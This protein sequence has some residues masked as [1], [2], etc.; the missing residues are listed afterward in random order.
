MNT[1]ITTLKKELASYFFSPVGYVIAVL[2]YLFRGWEVY[3]QTRQLA[4][5]GA[6]RDLYS[7]F[8]IFCQSTN[9]M[10]VLVPPI[11]TM[12]CFAEERRSGSLEVLMTAPVRDV[13][14]VLGKW[15]AALSFF[16]LLWLPTLLV[17]WVLTWQ[18]FMGV[19][20]A[21]GPVLSG[22]LG[23]FLLG[24]LFLA[25]GCLTSSLTDNLLLAA[26]SA[27]LFNYTLLAW[28]S[29][30]G[31]L[32]PAEA[33]GIGWVQTIYQHVN[34]FDHLSNWFARGLVDTSQ[35]VFYVGGSVFFLFLT[36]KSMESRR[37]R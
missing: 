31:S 4:A 26:L 5:F 23:L 10:I 2:F 32:I 16:A 12:R 11:L 7:T 15:L 35:V 28:P 33:K 22:Y 17:L 37:W 18:P 13:E 19:D 3:A 25:A 1:I 21:F 6:D 36:V 14:V 27:L 34:V 20:L 29:L 8:Y 9:L 30:V 24:A